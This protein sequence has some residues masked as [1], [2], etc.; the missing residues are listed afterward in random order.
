MFCAYADNSAWN[1]VCKAAV[2]MYIACAGRADELSDIMWENV[3]Q[4]EYEGEKC[5]IFKYIKEK[6]DGVPEEVESMLGDTV[7]NMAFNLYTDIFCYF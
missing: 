6:K 1:V 4:V 3:R 5:W 7:S 2:L